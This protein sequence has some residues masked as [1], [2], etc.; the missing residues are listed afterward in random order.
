MKKKLKRIEL[1]CVVKVEGPHTQITPQIRKQQILA[2]TG[3][4]IG[5]DA[6]RHRFGHGCLSPKWRRFILSIN[7]LKKQKKKFHPISLKKNRKL[8]SSLFLRPQIWP[9]SGLGFQRASVVAP[10][11]AAA[12]G[13]KSYLFGPFLK[14]VASRTQIQ[15]RISSKMSLNLKNEEK[16]LVLSSSDATQVSVQVVNMTAKVA[17][18]RRWQK[19]SWPEG[20]KCNAPK[21][22]VSLFLFENGLPG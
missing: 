1:H 20:P 22:R 19:G 11:R 7:A 8:L 17:N 6:K 10:P 9:W 4:V 13:T 12:K 3:R 15:G 16:T 14:P 2:A 21:V 5:S 18:T